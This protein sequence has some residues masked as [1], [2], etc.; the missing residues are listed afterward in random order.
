[1]TDRWLLE[2]AMALLNVLIAE[3]D[4]DARQLVSIPPEGATLHEIERA[5]LIAALDRT[6]W[7]QVKAAKLLGVSAR[8][9]FYKMQRYQVYGDNPL[10]QKRHHRPHVMPPGPRTPRVKGKDWRVNIG[11]F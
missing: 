9:F 7:V 4:R 11:T 8:V 3:R 10:V 6:G 5:A 1:M 2:R